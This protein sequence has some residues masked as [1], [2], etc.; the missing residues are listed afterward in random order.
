[1]SSSTLVQKEVRYRC[2]YKE[3]RDDDRRV[4]KEFLSASALIERRRE[5]VAAEGSAQG[6]AALLE[7]DAYDEERSEDDFRVRQCRYECLHLYPR[8]YHGAGNR[9]KVRGG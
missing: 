3:N 5:V 1:M 2:Q 7:H 6:G 4:E 8:E 9:R